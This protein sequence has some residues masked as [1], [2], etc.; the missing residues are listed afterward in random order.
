LP[1]HHVGGS[2]CTVLAALLRGATY[3][4]LPGFHVA[5]TLRT[6]RGADVTYFGGVPTMMLALLEHI[7]DGS[8]NLPTL[9]TAMVGGS[10][11][12]PALITAVEQA[13]GIEVVNGYGQSEAPSALQTRPGDSAVVKAQTIGR[14]NPHR[15]VTILDV[16]GVAVGPGVIG[17]LCIRGDLVMS[18]YWN[19]CGAP[20]SS[21]F[22]DASW[23]HTGDLAAEDDEGV[24]T[25]HGRLRDV[26]IRGGENIYPAEVE[27][28]LATHPSIADVAVIAAPDE[29]WGDVP[30]AFVRA[31]DGGVLDPVELE[32]FARARLAGFKVPRAWRQVSEFPVTASGKIQ[33]FKL[34][35]QLSE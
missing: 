35:A 16:D 27:S 30:V 12:A 14:P 21:A 22:D 23:L 24:V 5:Q 32:T 25:L 17:E 6:L 1:F 34:A 8:P 19:E 3:V 11:V 7:G 10:T 13:F 4:I 26:I 29:R 18:G 28:V 31:T 20:R 9:R 15:A 2:V 33:K